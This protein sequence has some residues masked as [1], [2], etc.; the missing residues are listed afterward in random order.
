MLQLSPKQKEVKANI[1]AFASLFGI[2]PNW[3]VAV[4]LVESSLGLYQ[5]SPTNCLGVFQMSSVAM[6]DLLQEMQKE[7]DEL[8]DIAC[9]IA[10]LRLL[11][12]RW[13]SIETATSHFCDPNDRHFY[14][15]KVKRFMRELEEG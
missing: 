15:D 7:D 1:E 5:R 4:A 13:G 12:R 11:Y 10:F 8:C 9:G 14:V 6:K 3:A 2:D